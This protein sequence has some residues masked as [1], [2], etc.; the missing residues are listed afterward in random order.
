MDV[1]SS[2]VRDTNLILWMTTSMAYFTFFLCEKSKFESLALLNQFFG[3]KI[4]VSRIQTKVGNL[5]DIL[6]IYLY[7]YVSKTIAN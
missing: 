6:L 7:L 1:I 5:H 4:K 3:G 2:H